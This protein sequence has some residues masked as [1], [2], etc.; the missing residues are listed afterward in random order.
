MRG[1]KAVVVVPFGG[2]TLKVQ[3]L[4]CCRQQ[5]LPQQP[6]PRAPRTGTQ[7]RARAM[8]CPQSLHPAAGLVPGLQEKQHARLMLTSFNVCLQ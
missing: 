3:D 1:G 8:C 2:E 4:R 6:Q 7:P 5:V